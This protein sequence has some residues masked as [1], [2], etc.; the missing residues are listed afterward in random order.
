MEETY[1]SDDDDSLGNNNISLSTTT[2]QTT[3][4]AT[5]N[6]AKN[7]LISASDK[8]GMGG[9][10]RQRINAILLRESGKSDFMKRQVALDDASNKRIQQMKERLE[11][12]DATSTNDWRKEIK[13]SIVDP[14]LQR[15]R[16]QR[17]PISTCC[18]VDMDSFFISCHILDNPHLAE[19]PACVGGT[20]MISTSNYVARKY[21]VRAA[22]PG[23]LGSKLVSELS[24]GKEK[25][26]FVKSDFSLYRKKSAEV[27]DILLQYDPSL[28]MGSLDEAY[29]DIESY[30]SIQLDDKNLSHEDISTIL[31]S[32]ALHTNHTQQLHERFPISVI[33]KAAQELLHTIRQKVKESTGLTCSAGLCNNYLLAK[34]ASDIN[35]PNGQFFL[36]SEEN[37]INTFINSLPTRKICGIGRVMEK[38]L[39]GACGI[40][41]VQ[42]LYNKRAE[43][44]FLFKPASAQSLLRVSIGYSESKHRESNEDDDDSEEALHRKGI[45]TE[46][47]FS[48][49]SDWTQM[50]T[51]LEGI[52]MSL[53][54]DLRDKNLRPKTITLKIK[55]A[56]FD[57][58]TRATTR[59]IA[60]FGANNQRQSAQD[61]VDIVIRLLKDAK[62]EHDKK[63]KAPA[64]LSTKKIPFSVRLLGIRCSNFQIGKDNQTSLINHYHVA[65]SSDDIDNASADSSSDK[66]SPVK[67][68]YSPKPTNRQVNKKRVKSKMSPKHSLGGNKP[69]PSNLKDDSNITSTENSNTDFGTDI[70]CPICQAYFK[71]GKVD[72]NAHIDS[73]L[74]AATVK[75][76]AKEETHEWNLRNK[77]KKR[78]LGDFFGS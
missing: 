14:M 18:V 11:E 9:I 20:S 62:R 34:V 50:C 78:K 44:Y 41:T 66:R 54:E 33:H 76:L 60:L 4:T 12:K 61:L 38:T 8:A 64:E 75:Q 6:E 31:K 19:V 24:N 73:C 17:R 47:T 77:K 1:N 7:L 72:I 67:N 2:K 26:T 25:L 58:L 45:S 16:S 36:G 43:V 52:S 39:R 71:S 30:L 42:D 28:S 57:I 55:L 23:Y 68:P 46:R 5:A 27:K 65:K 53:V 74:N 35:K 15:Y 3:N 40:E 32:K 48:P 70:Q 10:D 63:N 22:M 59:D 21:G 69:S 51:K 49:T 37:D 56:N 13:Q 29:M